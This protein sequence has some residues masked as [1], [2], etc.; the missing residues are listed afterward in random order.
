MT[1]VPSRSGAEPKFAEERIL[2]YCRIRYPE[3]FALTAAELS[4]IRLSYLPTRTFVAEAD[5]RDVEADL[6]AGL[7]MEERPGERGPYYVLSGARY[8]V[9][10][11]HSIARDSKYAIADVSSIKPRRRLARRLSVR[12]ASVVFHDKRQE[13]HCDLA[14]L[15]TVMTDGLT[16]VRRRQMLRQRLLRDIDTPK[17]PA[18]PLGD[19]PSR[20]SRHYAALRMML[21]LIAQRSRVEGATVATGVVMG[22][23]M[24]EVYVRLTKSSA[25]FAESRPIEVAVAG[26]A[27]RQVRTRLQ[28]IEDYEGDLVLCL[29]PPKG[30]ALAAGTEVRL[31][32]DGRFALRRHRDALDAFLAGTVEGDWENLA[33][34]LCRPRDLPPFEVRPLQRYLTE[35]GSQFNEQQRDAVAGAL[36]SP[37]A[38]LV[39]GP[40]GTGK[41]SVITELVLQ[42]IARG[43]RVLLVAPMHVAVDE[44]LGRIADLPGVFA[45]RVA[46]DDRKVREDLH[47]LLPDQVAQEYLRAARTPAGSRA[48]LWQSQLDRLAE[49]DRLIG[50]YLTAVDRANLVRNDRTDV[51]AGYTAWCMDND[52]AV[53]AVTNRLRD[54]DGALAGLAGAI[55]AAE[56]RRNTLWAQLSAISGGRRLLSRVRAFFAV[57]DPVAELATA[58]QASAG[59]FE[60]LRRDQ[61]LWARHRESARVELER[62]HQAHAQR[63]QAHLAG[64]ASH[65]SAVLAADR[66][67]VAAGAALAAG[68]G[69][70]PVQREVEGWRTVRG[71]AQAWIRRLGHR[72]VL[73]RRWFELSELDTAAADPGSGLA[74]QFEAELRQAANVVC[75][76][77]TGVVSA[78]LGDADFDTLIVDE[79]SRVVDSEF[80]IGAI[81]ARRW[82]LVG[83]QQQLPPYV[84]Q[85]DEHHLHALTALHLAD[86][87]GVDTEVAVRRL[88]ELWREDETMHTFRTTSVEQTAARLRGARH[89]P[90][91]R[92]SF[93]RHLHEMA[94]HSQ[95]AER[96]VLDAMRQHLVRSLFERCAED[97]PDGLFVALRLQHRSIDPIASLVRQPV[98]KGQY[99][100]P[101]DGVDVQPLVVSSFGTPVV[102]VDTSARGRR[103]EDHLVGHGFENQ[104]EA[105][106][107]R[108]IC[109]QLNRSVD[110]LG[111]AGVSVSVLTFYQHQSRRI[112]EVLGHPG[113]ADFSA[114]KFRVVD[115]IDRIQGQQSD[116]V[117]IS[118]CRARLSRKAPREHY[119]AWLQ[120]LRRLNVAVTRARRGLFLV[121][122]ADTLRRLNGV[123]AAEEFYRHLF[124]QIQTNPAAMTMVHDL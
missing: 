65:D 118:F 4:H 106:W 83:D 82:V 88:A 102:F 36:S 70:D 46:G 101:P 55:V 38:F 30:I 91:Y 110:L 69:E 10:A 117:V 3:D 112:R 54:A 6:G 113:Y 31:R 122:H 7:V 12:P 11:N 96:T 18:Q 37:H 40:P 72:L 98:Y 87:E 16:T 20:V 2:E 21:D 5:L 28:S 62:L 8:D 121:G 17:T 48:R 115:V 49:Q 85:A 108:K 47:R 105:A 80:L 41:S 60:R 61:L 33:L 123:P 42:L 84:E 97:M 39:Q 45:L 58:Y 79:A 34:L 104:L 63:Y 92:H 78:D 116:V 19:L 27:D 124:E 23:R 53:T 114:L 86:R 13:A 68:T 90:T 107:V 56:V 44:V 59:H 77:T 89:W 57:T 52:R 67:Q 32:Q 100:T 93:R 119:G 50:A 95:P 73:E 64:L 81:R 74:D 66:Q 26:H 1:S 111:E 15:L 22:L 94:D 109:V 14:S 51:E 99:D 71:S 25:E 76:T 24:D 29:S 35:T 43:E 9:Y 120:D 75:A 103:A